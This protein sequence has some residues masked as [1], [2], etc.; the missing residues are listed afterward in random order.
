MLG[1]QL[2]KVFGNEAVGWDRSDADVTQ[3]ESLKL[4]VEKF[5]TLGH[6]QLRGL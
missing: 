3:V 5:K 1:G 4:K 6:Y 2:M